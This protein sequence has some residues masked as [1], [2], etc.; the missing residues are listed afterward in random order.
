M[1]RTE[2]QKNQIR[3]GLRHP[4]KWMK[5]EGLPE[6]KIRPWE[7]AAHI[8]PGVFSGSRD[9]FMWNTTWLYQNVFHMDKGPQ[10]VMGVASGVW[11]G[12]N[13]PIIGAYMDHKNYRSQVL[14]WIMRVSVLFVG[15]FSVIPLFH[16]GLSTWQR[17]V[18]II[19]INSI[20]SLFSTTKN[21]AGPKVYARITPHSSE[22]AKIITATAVGN[23]IHDIMVG[24]FWGIMGLKDILGWDAYTIFVVGAVAFTIPAMF[25]DMA[26]SFVLQRVP[27]TDSPAE[28][29]NLKETVLEIKES[30]AVMRHNKFFILETIARFITVFTPSVSDSDFYRFSGIN[31]TVDNLIASGSGKLNGELLLFIRNSVIGSPANFGQPF[32][33]PLIKRVGGPRNMLML[34]NMSQAVFSLLRYFVGFKSIPR[35]LTIW[36][37]EMIGMFFQKMDEVAKDIIKYEMLDYVEWKTGR[38]SEGVSMAVEGLLKKV[39]LDNID[40]VVGNLALTRVGFRADLE[41][42]QPP[43]Y[44]KWAT[45][46]YFLCPVLDHLVY[47]I[48]RWFYKYPASMRDQVEAELIERRRLAVEMAE[49]AASPL[50]PAE[51]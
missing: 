21:V 12:L 37:T 41:L 29:M 48:A 5:G 10:S 15:I 14:R 1:A 44:I 22:R 19:I 9:A 50:A 46:F 45:I 30:F 2:E 27:D 26:P 23:T 20:K 28:A 34:F 17:V 33:V 49:A 24:L 32:A 11:D 38:R 51:K 36:G 43:G 31:N 8:V 4:V 7:M 18:L 39:A 35:I 3:A 40:M 25:F 6:E 42:N 13:D 16:M 47:V